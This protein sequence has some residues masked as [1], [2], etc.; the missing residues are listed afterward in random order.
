MMLIL[1]LLS[2]VASFV[3][4]ARSEKAFLEKVE[5]NIADLSSAIQISVDELTSTEPT[6]EARLADYVQRLKHKGVKEISILSNEQEVIASSNPRQVGKKVNPKH[7]D[8]FI[9]ARFGEEQGGNSDPHREYNVL[10][11][12]VV[13]GE[14]QGYAHIVLH[15]DDYHTFLT[16]NHL[17]RVFTTILIFMIGIG[18]SI[19][20]SMK[21][22][23]PIY[24]VV[25]AAK[26]IAAGDLSRTLPNR[27]GDEI[28]ELNKSFNEMV[29][30][31]RQERVLEER[32]RQ[33]EQLSTIGQ[34]AS[35]IAH[36]IRNPLN[37]I[38]LSIDHLKRQLSGWDS[39]ARDEAADLMKEIKGEIFRLNQMIENFL[40]Y[41]SP[42]RLSQ[43]EGVLSSLIPEVLQVTRHKAKENGVE[44]D[45]QVEPEAPSVWIDPEQMKTCL[46]NIVLNAI[47]SM[48]SGGRL[49]IRCGADEAQG[50]LVVSFSDT[51]CGIGGEEIK[52]IFKPYFTTKKLGIGL[53]LALTKRIIEEHGGR[54]EVKSALGVGTDVAISLPWLVGEAAKSIEG[55]VKA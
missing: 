23:E 34:M 42:L 51:G 14:Q 30:R 8:L 41:G 24:E 45:F 40:R 10:V 17:K 54:I 28:G 36:E 31:L 22:T 7:K 53:G 33:A 52:K 9:T 25:S 47:E 43:C 5:D 46:S 6:N 55:E 3:Y 35:G 11:P 50:C 20:L 39:P 32:L 18:V 2:L 21:Y 15:L 19:F 38:S 12:I 13:G 27:R 48:P 29:F 37:F 49:T 44:I 26:K 1:S 4:N 16:S